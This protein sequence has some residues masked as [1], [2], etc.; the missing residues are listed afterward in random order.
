MMAA[1]L[2]LHRQVRA[3]RILVGAVLGTAANCLA[4]LVCGNTAAYLLLVHF[5]LNPL[6]LLACFRE[7]NSKEFLAD[8]CV[9]Y[10]AFLLLGGIM[11]WLYAGGDGAVSYE[12]AAV[13]AL[14]LLVLAVFWSKRHL[15]DCLRYPKVRICCKDRQLRLRALAD[16]GNLLRDPYTGKP[17]TLVDRKIYEAAYGTPEAVRLIPYE[18]LGCRLGLLEAVTITELEFTYG[19]RR[20]R[21]N[22]AVLGLAEHTLF[23]AKPYQMILNIQELSAEDVRV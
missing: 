21:V 1:N 4:F 20:C 3:Y 14:C 23:E 9:S 12:A 15:K 17:V 18:S 6:V 5:V 8:L 11:E 22:R 13:L 10:A 7:K 16:S 19:N 2:F